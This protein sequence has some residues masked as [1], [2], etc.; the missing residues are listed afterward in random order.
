[1][2]KGSLNSDF[3]IISRQSLTYTTLK[4]QFETVYNDCIYAESQE[5][6]LAI[7]MTSL[8]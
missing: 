1:M 3:G 7:G 4:K 6:A 5:G 2:D 8:L